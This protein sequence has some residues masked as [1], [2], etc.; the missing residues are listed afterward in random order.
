M[1]GKGAQ[2]RLWLSQQCE[3][4]PCLSVPVLPHNSYQALNGSMLNEQLALTHIL[5]FCCTCTY[6]HPLSMG[7][8]LTYSSLLSG[9]Q[10]VSRVRLFA[11]PWTAARQASLSIPNSCSLLRLMS[12]ER[13][14]RKDM[15]GSHKLHLSCS[16]SYP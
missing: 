5:Y 14:G 2:D 12:I 16:R 11:I 7:L 9:V 4:A 3:M 1:P 8:Y 10:L 15:T 6:C 13:Y